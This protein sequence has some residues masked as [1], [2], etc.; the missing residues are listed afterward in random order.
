MWYGIDIPVTKDEPTTEYN[1][2]KV[3]LFGW[4]E[5]D[6]RKGRKPGDI[7]KIGYGRFFK[8]LKA[9]VEAADAHRKRTG[10]TGHHVI[11]QAV[12]GFAF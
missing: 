5:P 1:P 9:A 3:Y 12:A 10:K 7:R 8:T 6:T 2:I 4:E 11:G